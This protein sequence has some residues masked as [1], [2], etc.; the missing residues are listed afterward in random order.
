MTP[1]L[2]SA[3]YTISE[4][5]IALGLTAAIAATAVPMAS[6]ILNQHRL[7]TTT[8][9][10]AFEIARARMQAVGQNRFTRIVLLSATRYQ[11]QTSDNGVS[12]VEDAPSVVL[13]SGFAA[14]AGGS[15]SP[16]FDRQGLA[17]ASTTITITGPRGQQTIA[18]TVL[19]R[20]TTS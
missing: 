15:G 13:P 2:Q 20:V 5:V 16:R 10:L 12:Y 18:T 14:T 19:G 17:P 6:A 4:L 11:R 3:G 8:R 7:T 1:K 9:Q